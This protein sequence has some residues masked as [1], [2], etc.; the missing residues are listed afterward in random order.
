MN[1]FKSFTKGFDKSTFKGVGYLIWT[2]M[3]KQIALWV[4][5]G[6]FI[7]A[8]FIGEFFVFL[9]A[10]HNSY[11]EPAEVRFAVRSIIIAGTLLPLLLIGL[12]SIPNTIKSLQK[13]T[14]IKRIGSTRL[15]EESF[16]LIL[17]IWYLLLSF[18]VVTSTIGILSFMA[19]VMQR[20][21]TN[22]LHGIFPAYL[23]LML[24]LLMFVS[25]G[26]LFGSSSI[27]HGL[28]IGLTVLLFVVSILFGGF[29]APMTNAF[30]YALP[31]FTSIMIIIN[32][33]G[34][35]SYSMQSIL[36]QSF[37]ATATIV[38]ILY[39]VSLSLV[40]FIGSAN[41]MSFTKIN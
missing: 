32:P 4:F 38:S 17:F 35:A 24:V 28:V 39:L 9:N 20:P 23:F 5:V 29:L 11:Y 3:K 8:A 21:T 10:N 13:T 41:M 31:N 7:A 22:S 12:F 6:L 25:V 2:S 34:F 26:L 14:L 27:S 18:I 15:T 1:V 16:V 33:I 40:S 19:L 30:G 37:G 36:T